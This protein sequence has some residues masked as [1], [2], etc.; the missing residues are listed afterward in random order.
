MHT[1]DWEQIA[2]NY[3]SSWLGL[4]G[5]FFKFHWKIF[6]STLIHPKS[7]T[8]LYLLSVSPWQYLDIFIEL[9]VCSKFTNI[10]WKVWEQ[11]KIQNEIWAL[12]FNRRE[13]VLGTLL[14]VRPVTKNSKNYKKKSTKPLPDIIHLIMWL[15]DTKNAVFCIL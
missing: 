9:N 7:V 1:I 6:F 11:E 5:F 2:E 10:C 12:I 3:S 14:C 4:L 15:V 13:P 8:S